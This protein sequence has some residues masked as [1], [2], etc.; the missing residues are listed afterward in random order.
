M[1][2]ADGVLRGDIGL[3]F[4]CTLPTILIA[5]ALLLRGRCHVARDTLVAGGIDPQTLPP[6][7]P[8][9]VQPTWQLTGT[10]VLIGL[11]LLAVALLV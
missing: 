10:L 8:E 9:P 5:S 1:V 2:A 11:S 3:A 4:R 6:S 7:L